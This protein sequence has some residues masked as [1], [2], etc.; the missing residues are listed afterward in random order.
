MT[1]SKE[2]L[3]EVLPKYEGK[4]VLIAHRQS[5]DDIVNEVLDAH[6]C[7]SGDYDRLVL[8]FDRFSDYEVCELLFDFLKDNICY[9]EESELSQTTKS[10]AA[11]LVT[12]TCDCKGYALFIAGVLDALNRSGR[13]IDW[14]FAFAGYN[15]NSIRHVFVR[16]VVDGSEIWIDPVLNEFN[17]RVPS[18]SFVKLK[19]PNMALHRVSGIINEEKSDNI[20]LHAACLEPTDTLDRQL[21]RLTTCAT[22]GVYQVREPLLEIAV[23]E[24]STDSDAIPIAMKV[25]TMLTEPLVSATE[26]APQGYAPS[27]AY[28]LTDGEEGSPKKSVDG[29]NGLLWGAALVAILLM[30]NK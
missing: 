4:K 16:A 2:R 3:L 22:D 29:N 15:S 10:P 20:V 8:F 5:I 12:G 11:I 13:S 26:A 18:P 24:E 1:F 27:Q 17:G 19:R 25:D 21:N 9:S 28:A 7:F 23:L 6:S 14:C 30:A